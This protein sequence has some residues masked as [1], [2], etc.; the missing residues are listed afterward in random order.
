[1]RMIRFLIQHPVSVFVLYIALCLIAIISFKYLPISLLPNIDVPQ[2]KILIEEPNK[3]PAEIEH[4]V[5]APIR[6]KMLQVDGIID[7]QSVSSFEKGELNLQLEYG[8]DIDYV[9]LEVNEKIDQIINNLSSHIERPKV[10]KKKTEDIPTFFLSVSYK[11]N[12]KFHDFHLLS[13]FTDQVVRRRLEQLSEVALADIHGQIKKQIV[14]IPDENKI[15]SLGITLEDLIKALETQ[16]LIFGSVLFKE[17][18]FQYLLRLGQPIQSIEVIRDVPILLN[19]RLFHLNELAEIKVEERDIR[20]LYFVNGSQGISLAVIKSKNAKVE[21][22]KTQIDVLIKQLENENPQIQIQVIRD[23]AYLLKYTIYSLRT[24]L[25]LGCFLAIGLVF[26]FYRNW[27][28]SLLIGLTVPLSVLISLLFFSIAGMTINMITLSGII[29]GLGLMIDNGIIVLDNIVQ[30][31]KAEETVDEACIR[32]ANA[33]IRPLLTSMLTTC[34]VFLPLVFFS[35]VVGALFYDQALSISIGLLLSFIVSITFIPVA[36][37]SLE[38]KRK[39]NSIRRSRIDK[40]Y[41]KGLNAVYKYSFSFGLVTILFLIVNCFLFSRLPLKFMPS[42]QS[43]TL[44]LSID[45]K[46][47]ISFD[48]ATYRIE[49]L[50]NSVKKDLDSYDIHLGEDQYLIYQNR[51]SSLSTALIYIKLN[52]PVSK[53]LVREKLSNLLEE[54]YS[55]AYYEFHPETSVF[56]L[57]FPKRRENIKVEI[58]S[59]ETSLIDEKQLLKQISNDLIDRFPSI[60]IASP[61]F[62]N[63]ILISPKLEELLLH[64]INNI[65]LYQRLKQLFNGL[66]I[67]N[68]RQAESETPIIIGKNNISSISESL[69][70]EQILTEDGYQIPL[71]YLVDINNTVS[72]QQIEASSKGRFLP[73]YIKT[74]KV[75]EVL[76]YLEHIN[77]QEGKFNFS[78]RSSYYQNRKLSQELFWLLLTALGLLYFIMIIQFESFIQPL[79][80]L[81]EIPIS[82]SGSIFVL[83]LFGES[84]NI[85]AMIGM[86]VTAGIVIN[87]SIIKI[88]TINF[89]YRSGASLKEAIHLGGIKRLNAIIMTSLTTILSVIPIFFSNDLGSTL[90]YPLALAL[91]GGLFVGTLM[92]L[93]LIPLIYQ[94][95]Y[96]SQA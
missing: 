30:E 15:A 54:N 5:V 14:I 39:H 20:G 66:A 25:I 87:D 88:D 4:Q 7:I 91:S 82:L 67:F 76:R 33:M 74:E 59:L 13:Q 3:S 77:S 36:Y 70:K 61:P 42:I 73:L 31:R 19:K 72:W 29:L 55:S 44:E 35:G 40:I 89:L 48:I 24:N 84:I 49:S 32:G 95:I 52:K 43:K 92:S 11:E 85:M 37:F 27:R 21:S 38:K 6:R 64:K 10:I 12:A 93:Y 71:K 47:P 60:E 2:I 62:K 79:I 68:I 94:K 56:E 80:V 8:K 69:A 23:N 83:F 18:N 58:Y 65:D 16:N 63:S 46:E 53:T 78:I 90:Q 41:I 75:A 9:F 22:L 96:E 1:M 17:R 50:L 26:L 34:S 51:V 57:L 81:L 86:V 28:N 45:W